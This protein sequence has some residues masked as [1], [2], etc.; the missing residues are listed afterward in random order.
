ML[1][2]GGSSDDPGL[3]PGGA[4]GGEEDVIEGFGG[5]GAFFAARWILPPLERLLVVF[6]ERYFLDHRLLYVMILCDIEYN[7]QVIKRRL[8]YMGIGCRR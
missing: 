8:Q 2:G 7:L 4:G 6:A 3:L 5:L 1:I